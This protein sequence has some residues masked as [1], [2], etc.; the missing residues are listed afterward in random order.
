[1]QLKQVFKFIPNEMER[2]TLS[3]CGCLEIKFAGERIAR[4]AAIA[5]KQKADWQ[6]FSWPS[7]A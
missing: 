6:E 7:C 3:W 4:Q 5:Q 2:S 1:L